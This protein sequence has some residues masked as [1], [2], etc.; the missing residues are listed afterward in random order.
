MSSQAK[1]KVGD[2]IIPKPLSEIRMLYFI[3]NEQFSFIIGKG[4]PSSYVDEIKHTWSVKKFNI[5]HLQMSI[6][7]AIDKQMSFLVGYVDTT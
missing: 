6:T 1:Y 3:Q 4:G 7:R 2:H 5:S